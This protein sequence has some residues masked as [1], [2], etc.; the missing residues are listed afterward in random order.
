META[1]R[2]MRAARDI[3]GVKNFSKIKACTHVSGSRYHKGSRVTTTATAWTVIIRDCQKH[4]RADRGRLFQ[5]LGNLR[6]RSVLLKAE[7]DNFLNA[8]DVCGSFLDF[9]G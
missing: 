2:Q 3:A 1:C 4:W 6:P 7:T 5:K 8:H 9:F